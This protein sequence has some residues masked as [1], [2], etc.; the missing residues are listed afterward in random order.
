M[1]LLRQHRF[2][3]LAVCAILALALGFWGY[4]ETTG[5]STLDAAYDTFSLLAFNFH[6]PPDGSLPFTLQLARFVVPAVAAFA[7]LTALSLLLEDEWHLLRAR[8]QRGHVVVCGLGTRG[9][10]VVRS[11][12]REGEQRRVV[13]IDSDRNNPNIDIAREL[14]A[15]V[16]FGD[17]TESDLLH[18]ARVP[19]AESLVCLLAGDVGNAEVASR[20]RL[21]CADRRQPLAV[22]CHVESMDLVAELTSAGIE[23][24]GAGVEIEWF[25]VPERAAKTLLRRHREHRAAAGG[26]IAQHLVVLGHD[27]LARAI[28][29]E[30]SRQ[31]AVRAEGGEPLRLT[32]VDPVAGAWSRELAARHPIIGRAAVIEPFEDDL[33]SPSVADRAREMLGDATGVFVCADSDSDGLELG[34]AAS[35][36]VGAGQAVV[37]RLLLEN[38]AFVDLLASDRDSPPFRFFSIVDETC[39]YETITDG[40]RESLALAIHETYLQMPSPDGEG[41]APAAVPWGDVAPEFVTSSRSQ[42]E[43][44]TVKLKEL[45]CRLRPHDGLKPPLRFEPEEVERLARLEHERWDAE[46]KSQGWVNGKARDDTRKVH[47]SVDVAWEELDKPEADKDRRFV[48]ELPRMLTS[49]GYEIYRT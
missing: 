22:Y 38:P 9:L 44:L 4:L 10:Q 25:S 32:I 6:E 20:A 40:L 8:R 2:G 18:A 45:R 36:I 27:E 34:F 3:I 46:K 5:V 21:L 30:A 24:A 41:A 33:R 31:W 16:L 42:A 26:A 11:I 19:R 39:S 14:G 43:H 15:I 1:R 7:T 23:T 35:R 29:V 13:A 47:P 49:F 28:V 12:E 48:E 37:V 17:A